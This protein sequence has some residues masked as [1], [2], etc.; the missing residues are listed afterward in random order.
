MHF[1]KAKE[2]LKE[3]TGFTCRTRRLKLGNSRRDF[4]N[5]SAQLW[6]YSTFNT[7]VIRFPLSTKW[8][9]LLFHL[10]KED[11]Q[12]VILKCPAVLKSLVPGK[13]VLPLLTQPARWEM[14]IWEGWLV[15]NMKAQSLA[16]TLALRRWNTKLTSNYWDIIKSRKSAT[17]TGDCDSSQQLVLFFPQSSP[18]PIAMLKETSQAE[19]TLALAECQKKPK[20]NQQ[21]KTLAEKLRKSSRTLLA[22]NYFIL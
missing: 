4:Q 5:S 8:E 17:I 21:T 2:G 3:C 20:K 7:A 19:Q 16:E 13:H 10:E 18:I 11:Q 12:H 22:A 9:V 1:F 14:W 6:N 15:F